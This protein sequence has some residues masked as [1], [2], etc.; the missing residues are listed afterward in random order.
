MRKLRLLIALLILPLSSIAATLVEP[1]PISVPTG[2]KLEQVARAIKSA[3]PQRQWLMSDK[4]PGLIEAQLL[5]RKHMLKVAIAYSEQTIT[6]KYL[7][8]TEMDYQANDGSPTIHSKYM[9]WTRNLA[10][11][12]TFALNIVQSG[13]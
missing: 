4:E 7:D 2:L 9:N 10:Q 12:I 11:D 8:S 3:G 13:G 5:V 1:P 6:M